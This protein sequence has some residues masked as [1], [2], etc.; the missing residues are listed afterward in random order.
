MITMNDIA[1]SL[2]VSKGTVSKALAGAPDISE[3]TRNA[4]V[5]RAVEMGYTRIRRGEVAPRLCVFVMH[6]DYHTSDDFGYDII[7]GFLQLAEPNGYHVDVIDL[8]EKTQMSTTYDEYMLANNY[9]GSFFLGINNSDPWI[10]SVK[11]CKTPTVL[12]DNPSYENPFITYV[13]VD[14]FEAMRL[15][16]GHLWSLGHRKIGYLSSGSPEAFVYQQR[17]IAFSHTMASFGVPDAPVGMALLTSECIQEQFPRLMALGCTAIL[18][19][20][21]LLAQAV[22]THCAEL[23]IR[24]P[25]DLSVVG[26]DDI[27]L[28]SVTRPPLTTIRQDRVQ[29]GKSSFYALQSQMNHTPIG[30]LQL[31]ATLVVRGSAS[32]LRAG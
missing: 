24:I 10:A 12:F 29:L 6:M 13:G 28:C 17:Q 25:N 15:S 27:P 5:A 32:N 1:L 22:L 3:T 7:N 20:H 2:G 21:D 9:R 30:T 26:F 23:N 8:D 19:N 16:V 4:I 31:H 11:Q 14:N 18:C